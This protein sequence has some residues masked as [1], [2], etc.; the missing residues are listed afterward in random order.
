[1]PSYACK[2]FDDLQ[3]HINNMIDNQQFEEAAQYLA[4]RDKVDISEGYRMLAAFIG[5]YYELENRKNL[6]EIYLVK[7]CELGD[8]NSCREHTYWLVQKGEYIKAEA[9]LLDIAKK[10]SDPK[11]AGY[12][13]SLYHNR[14]WDGFSK[15]KAKYWQYKVTEFAKQKSNN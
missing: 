13:V 7:G 5:A 1:M 4:D 9:I 3:L 8:F 11:A 2:E 15:E 6:S 12:L 10:H 14:K